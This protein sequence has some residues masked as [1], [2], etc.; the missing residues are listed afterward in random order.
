MILIGSLP[1]TKR[2]VANYLR[3]Y[4]LAT[5]NDADNIYCYELQR[6]LMAGGF[7]LAG[8]MMLCKDR[9]WQL[10]G[11]RVGL[12][13]FLWLS[14]LRVV[15]SLHQQS[16]GN[17][18]KNLQFSLIIR[19]IAIGGIVLLIYANGKKYTAKKQPVG[20]GD[21]GTGVSSASF[22]SHQ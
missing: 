19:F 7:F 16:I 6:T 17:Y 11:G 5:E 10:Y 9:E 18:Y 13:S 8:F 22:F 4:G 12:V 14:L 1:S 21:Q 2:D 20:R 3:T 15:P